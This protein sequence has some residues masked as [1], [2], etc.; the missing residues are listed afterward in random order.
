MKTFPHVMS[1]CVFHVS[2]SKTRNGFVLS[3]LVLSISLMMVGL[4]GLAFAA[5]S[6]GRE[7][8][9]ADVKGEIKGPFKIKF[10]KEEIDAITK[11]AKQ[12]KDLS[13]GT[14]AMEIKLRPDGSGLGFP[15][16]HCPPGCTELGVGSV[17]GPFSAK[18]SA[19]FDLPKAG[20]GRVAYTPGPDEPVVIISCDC[21]PP[22]LP[23][24]H[25][26]P[27]LRPEC[28]MA[29]VRANNSRVFIPRC[30][31][32]HC[33]QRCRVVFNRQPNGLLLLGCQCR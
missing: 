8:S 10:S 1:C 27:P 4:I 31:N 5:S 21:P 28:E 22:E 18:Y 12:S 24:T 7:I 6:D 15:I 20:D 11:G 29:W 19:R 3:R 9:L 17:W 26:P 16:R 2:P 14:A 33:A 32:R 25:T 30:L 23:G 13:R